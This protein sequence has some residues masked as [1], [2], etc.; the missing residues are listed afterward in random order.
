LHAYKFIKI[1]ENRVHSTERK[2][3]KQRRKG[4]N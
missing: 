1:I 4:R 2:L 3:K